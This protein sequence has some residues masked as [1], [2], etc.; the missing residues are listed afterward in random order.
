MQSTILVFRQTGRERE[1]G[2]EKTTSLDFG[3]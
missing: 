2:K 1:K 3:I